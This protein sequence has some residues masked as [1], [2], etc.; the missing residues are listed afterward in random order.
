MSIAT[1]QRDKRRRVNSSLPESTVR[2][3][4]QYAA[5]A[6]LTRSAALAMLIVAGLRS[7]HDAGQ[8]RESDQ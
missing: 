6:G 4:D 3:I 8:R 7:V 5:Y 2:L 1:G